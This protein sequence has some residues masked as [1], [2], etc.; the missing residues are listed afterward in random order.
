[1]SELAIWNLMLVERKLILFFLLQVANLELQFG[2]TKSWLGKMLTILVL[3][4]GSKRKM[5][6]SNYNLA[7]PNTCNLEKKTCIYL[8][9]WIICPFVKTAERMCFMGF[10]V[11]HL[12]R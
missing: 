11:I 9:S 10:S 12:I 5:A 3:Q 8:L 7:E 2:W 4:V 1:M 6:I